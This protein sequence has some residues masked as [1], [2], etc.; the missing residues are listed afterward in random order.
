MTL[1]TSGPV[2]AA[3]INGELGRAANAPFSLDDP[4]VRALAGIATG[5]IS[6]AD[7][8]GKSSEIV[9][10]LT[11]VASIDRMDMLFSAE[12]WASETTKR[13][14][15]PAGTE[16]GH[17]TRNYAIAVGLTSGGQAGSFGGRLILENRGII[18]GKA[19]AAN[20]GVGGNAVYANLLGRD[21]QM[22][23]IIN[24][25]TIRGGGGGGGVGGTGGGGY[26]DTPTTVREPASGE[27]G[28][29][30][31][32]QWYH[33]GPAVRIWWNGTMI[34]DAQPGA[35]ITQLTTG[36]WTYFRGTSFGPSAYRIYRQQTTNVRTNTNGGA[37]GAGGQG[38]GYGVA[39]GAGSNGAAGGTNA[40]AGGRGGDGGGWGENG[41]AG[42][43]GVAGNRTAGAGGAAGGLA[44]AYV[45]GASRVSWVATGT[46]QGRA[47][48]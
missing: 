32:Y 26:Y 42:A 21:G 13:I 45:D 30:G 27:L 43:T 1:P 46:R 12:D 11:S 35:G 44:G 20:S 9:V 23:E 29:A 18:S 47:I 41:A 28:Q 17:T 36:G 24:S 40:G 15:V 10:N 7:F 2:T 48:N 19:G 34:Y 3:M 6:F 25:G 4:D 39:A 5:P 8:Y 31:V 37:G 14:I 33:N 16:L 38:Q 22:L